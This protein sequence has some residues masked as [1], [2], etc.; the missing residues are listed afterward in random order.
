MVSVDVRVICVNWTD[1]I[2]LKHIPR[3]V[4]F[5]GLNYV[6]GLRGK[7][8]DWQYTCVYW[9]RNRVA[10]DPWKEIQNVIRLDVIA[11]WS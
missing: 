11:T 5:W 2:F 9:R 6:Y 7:N 4:Q 1:A 8:K 10:C 3:D